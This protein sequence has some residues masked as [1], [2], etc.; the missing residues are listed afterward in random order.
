MSSSNCC[1][2]TFIQISQ[3]TGQVVCYFDLFQNFPQFV[4]IHTIRGFGIVNKAKVNVFLEYSCFFDDPTDVGNLISDSSAF[5]KSSLNIW[6]FTVHVLLKPGL[7]NFEH[8]FA[9]VWDECNCVVVWTFFGFR[10]LKKEKKNAALNEIKYSRYF[11][12]RYLLMKFWGLLTSPAARLRG[13]D[14]LLFYDPTSPVSPP[15][16]PHLLQAWAES[17]VLWGLMWEKL[18]PPALPGFPSSLLLIFPGSWPSGLPA[19][20]TARVILLLPE[21]NAHLPFPLLAARPGPSQY[22]PLVPVHLPMLKWGRA[23]Q[24][25]QNRARP[26][27]GAS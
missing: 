24:L 21:D 9:S 11:Y 4:V 6:K 16:L 27:L 15:W 12:S 5:S 23:Q 20:A 10:M 7:K 25:Q 22:L 26:H 14:T 19:A 1:F 13:F 18:R 8:Y 2:V 17:Q 3:G